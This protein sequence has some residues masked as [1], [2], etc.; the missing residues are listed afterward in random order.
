MSGPHSIDRAAVAAMI[1]LC[2]SWGFQQ[3]SVKLALPEVAPIAQAAIRS[4]GASV[5]VSAFAWW[6]RRDLRIDDGTLRPGILIGLIFAAEFVLLFLA[7]ARTDAARV[8]MLLY[9]APFVVAAGARFLPVP[10]ALTLDR[11]AG[12]AIAF[13]GVALLLS[14]AG[15]VLGPGFWGDLMALGA[16]MLWGLTTLVIK[17]TSLRAAEPAKVLLYQ[18]VVSAAAMTA[19]SLVAGEAWRVPVRGF[20]WAVMAYQVVW[21]TTVTYLV[22]FWLVSRYPPARLSVLSFLAPVFGVMFGHWVL[23]EPLTGPLLVSL[24]LV[25][26]GI[27]LVNRPSRVG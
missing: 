17:G 12:I 22:W 10:E 27:V 14:P 23:G 8:A 24:V 1:V 19:A 16:G 20:T 3:V 25:A 11:W 15:A 4:I 18:L 7:L 21:I 9:T 2:A 13:A 5:L 26:T 6:T